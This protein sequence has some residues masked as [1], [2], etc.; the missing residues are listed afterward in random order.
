L[1]DVNG[2]TARSIY[3]DKD[4]S[5]FKPSKFEYNGEVILHVKGIPTEQWD[6]AELD[7]F[8]KCARRI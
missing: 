4:V 6:D 5:A 1:R 7:E 2:K 3:E 8:E